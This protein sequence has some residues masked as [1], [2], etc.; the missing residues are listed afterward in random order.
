MRRALRSRTLVV[1]LGLTLLTLFGVI[2]GPWITPFSPTEMD[3]IAVLTPPDMTHWL[4]T[5]SF[6]R[7]VLSRVLSGGRV[8]LFISLC[9]VGIGAVLGVAAGMT[10]AWRGGMFEV[11]LMAAC[12]LLFAFPS[13]VLALFMMVVLGFGLHNII[14]AV[15]LA[16]LPI[17]ARLARNLTRTLMHEPF[18]QAARL[19]GQGGGR[20]LLREIL[21]NIFP[22]LL[23]QASVGLAFGIVMEAGLSFLG[24]GVQP[25]MPSL[26]VILADGREYFT[27]GPWVLTMTGLVVSVALL[28]LNLLGDALRDLTDPRLRQAAGP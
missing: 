11:A 14:I 24:L 6:G 13:F 12:D 25:P 3:F 9:G 28:G 7:D 10:A 17:F 2:A 22:T 8:S 1:G 16:Y 21:P 20:I 5:D 26:G 15:A 19:M 23:V 18:V 4:G 27:R